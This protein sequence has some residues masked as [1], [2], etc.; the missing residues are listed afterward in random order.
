M[1]GT[2]TQLHTLNLDFNNSLTSFREGCFS[3]MP[4]LMRLSMCETRISNLWT[5]TAALSKL[6]SLVELRFQNCSC[7]NHTGPCQASSGGKAGSGQLQFYPCAQPA[8]ISS[9]DFLLRNYQYSGT[10]DMTNDLLSDDESFATHELLQRTSVESSDDSELDF[11][12]HQQRTSNWVERLSSAPH[13]LTRQTNLENSVKMDNLAI[14]FG[15]SSPGP[16][17][18]HFS[19][20]IIHSKSNEAQLKHETHEMGIFDDLRGNLNGC[21][22]LD[23]FYS[24]SI[25]SIDDKESYATNVLDSGQMGPTDATKKYSSHR[26]SP[27]HICFEK[28]YR[29]YMIASLPHLKVLDNLPIENEDREAAKMIVSQYYEYLPYNR[30]YKENIVNVLQKREM[31]TSTGL[32][33]PPKKMQKTPFF[34]EMSQ[35][36]FTRSISAAKVGSSAWPSLHSISKIR[37]IAKEETK[38]FRPRQ[39]EYH[40]CNPS[41][42]VFGTLDGELVIINHESGKLVSYLPSVG[43]LH[44][45]LGLCWIKKHPSK[46]HDFRR[47]LEHVNLCG[48]VYSKSLLNI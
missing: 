46:V 33:K 7:C 35:C 23:E 30:L 12:R 47:K 29:E 31:G 5:T 45:V 1:A 8:S 44:I 34:S 15:G 22:K 24:N 42:M 43:A 39:F 28:H 9:E 21:A 36:S 3:C 11:S 41:L 20:D 6:P 16:T 32:R 40:P 13:N 4:N 25:S 19:M 27:S 26:P 17:P 14:S 2:F 10:G 18:F 38:S 48:W 37:S